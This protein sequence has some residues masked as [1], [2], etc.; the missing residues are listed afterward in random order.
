M[1]LAYAV[2][3]A[4]QYII[5]AGSS[6][7]MEGKVVVIT[8]GGSGLGRLMALDLASQGAVLVLADVNREGLVDV[9]EEIGALGGEAYGH[10]CDVTDRDQVYSLAEQV[11]AELGAADVVVLNAG[12]VSGKTLLDV[13][14]K[15]AELTFNV[16]A[17]AHFWFVKAFLPGMKARNEGH[18]VSIASAAGLVGV[19]GLADYCASKFAAVGLM[20][21]LRL[22][23][24]RERSAVK[25]TTVMPFY[26][27]TGMF[28]G[29]TGVPIL[30]PILD[31]DYVAG[32]I[33]TAIRHGEKHLYLPPILG[34]LSL[35]RGILPIGVFDWLG[36]VLGVS[37]SMDDFSGRGQDFHEGT[38][39]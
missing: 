16:N 8:G 32:R 36:E 21:S 38:A 12:V 39:H 35:L 31:P 5:W 15:M 19:V 3:K 2:Y 10:L 37:N 18:I 34:Y 28:E 30:L 23:L 11:E 17:V 6:V 9:V 27:N 22:E 26:I 7:S 1:V 33:V 25:T 13:S 24:R 20:E 29:V 4:V 14:D